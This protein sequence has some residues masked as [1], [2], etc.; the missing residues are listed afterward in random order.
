MEKER[1]G[2]LRAIFLG[3]SQYI[4][5]L[6]KAHCVENC[7]Q[8]VTPPNTGF[9]VA[10]TSKQ[11]KKINPTPYQSAV[12][13]L[14]WL[15]LITRPDI[16]HSISKLSQRNQDPHTEHLANIKHVLKYLA[17]TE[18]MKLH[19]RQCGQPFLGYV[20]A[21]WAGDKVDRKSYYGYNYFLAG[22]PFSWRSEK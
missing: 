17:S 6:L 10:C 1:E 15:A 5:H 4:N 12:G 20:D 16:L 18:D 14:M 7:R 22:G 19:Y 3:H 11:C 8:A 13:E 21:D 9:Q 2:E